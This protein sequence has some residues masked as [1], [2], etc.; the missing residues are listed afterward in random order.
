MVGRASGS[1]TWLGAFQR[2][3]DDPGAIDSEREM[4][5]INDMHD[6]EA[7]SGEEGRGG[8]GGGGQYSSGPIQNYDIYFSA[9]FHSFF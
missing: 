6:L 2:F 7:G 9:L 1:G 8:G 3:A 5:M 4:Q